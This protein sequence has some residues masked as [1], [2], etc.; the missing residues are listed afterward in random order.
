MNFYIYHIKSPALKPYVQYI[1]FNYSIDKH[2]NKTLRSFANSNFCLGIVKD[3]M[4]SGIG[5]GKF[6]LAEKPG[7]HSYLT[8]IYT[9]PYDLLANGQQD[10]ICID[11]TP[12]GYYKFFRFQPKTFLLE[13]DVLSEAFEKDSHHF[14]ETVFEE[15]DFQKR[16]NMIETFLTKKALHYESPALLQILDVI[17]KQNGNITVA[18]IA[19]NLKCSQRKIHRQFV[20]YLDISPK[21]YI[22]VIRFRKS[23]KLLKNNRSNTAS[24][25]YEL[26]YADQ[27]HLI[28]E[29]KYFTGFSPKK[30]FRLLYSVDNT[31]VFSIQ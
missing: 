16:G 21:E 10:E 14:F 27:S 31:V 30:L 7:I 9:R 15:T 23:I 18:G 8:G 24:D 1:L 3:R 13:D 2:F 11:F 26:G 6:I 29:V 17:G 5:D 22:R 28:K 25:A 12:L 19:Q 20:Q 4:L